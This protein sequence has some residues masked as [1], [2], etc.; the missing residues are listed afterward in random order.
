MKKSEGQMSGF[1]SKHDGKRRLTHPPMSGISVTITTELQ[2]SC[3]T[4]S[5]VSPIRTIASRC[6]FPK[7]KA[8]TQPPAKPPGS[9]N[10]RRR[11]FS[12]GVLWR[13]GGG[14]EGNGTEGK[15]KRCKIEV[16]K[17]R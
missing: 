1:E 4:I 5:T 13:G 7:P 17:R 3:R 9:N 16:H 8:F 2:G 12:G 11:G 14:W 15:G 10:E 6:P